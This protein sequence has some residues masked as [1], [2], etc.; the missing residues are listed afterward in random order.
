MDV[1]I[2]FGAQYLIAIVAIVT[3]YVWY[4]L[5]KS[6]RRQAFIQAVIGLA[7][8]A[9]LVK[10]AGMLYPE[11]RPFVAHHF[12]PLFP[13]RGDNG[14]PS[15]HTTFGMLAA[16][17]ILPYARRWGWGLAALALIVGL[18]RVA[19]GV[20]S[21]QDIAGGVVVAA[22]SAALAYV[23]AKWLEQKWQHRKIASKA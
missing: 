22:I 18:C 16:L 21:L 23:A 17:T 13:Q 8:A 1:L 9:I 6:E 14:F 15:D 10:V 11:A 19:A 4:R 20:H 5:P 3:L 2:V 12:T 7:V